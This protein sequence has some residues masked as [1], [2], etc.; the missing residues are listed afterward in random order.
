MT[1]INML[2]PSR[3]FFLSPSC[4]SD[5]KITDYVLGILHGH[6]IPESAVYKEIDASLINSGD[7]LIRCFG[8]MVQVWQIEVIPFGITTRLLENLKGSDYAD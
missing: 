4:V 1:K 6:K 2:D 5:N 3:K 8:R 7:Y